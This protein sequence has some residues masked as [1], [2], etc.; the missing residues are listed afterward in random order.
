MTASISEP[1][2]VG[3]QMGRSRGMTHRGPASRSPS[4]NDWLLGVLGP[5]IGLLWAV[6]IGSWGFALFAA[7]ALLLGLGRILLGDA[8]TR[9]I[10]KLE[11]YAVVAALSALSIG[12]FVIVILEMVRQRPGWQGLAI[13]CFITGIAMAVIPLLAVMPQRTLRL[14][15]V[16]DPKSLPPLPPGTQTNPNI[17]SD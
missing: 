16:D 5:T 7:G 4:P 17:L 2:Q 14:L 15:H 1:D 6:T 10:T 3:S 11:S 9:F 8:S 12:C 13:I